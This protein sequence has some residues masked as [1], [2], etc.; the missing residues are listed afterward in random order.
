MRELPHQPDLS[1]LR[2][3]ARELQ[4]AAARGEV[5]TSEKVHAISLRVTLSSAQLALAREYGFSSWA[6]LKDEIERRAL[7]SP[8]HPAARYV[9][10]EVASLAELATAFDVIARQMSPSV[11]HDNRRFQDL[12]QRFPED[13]A[14]MLVVQ[15]QSRTVGGVLAVRKGWVGCNPADHRSRTERSQTGGSGDV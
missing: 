14:L 3:Q 5:A 10:R 1:Q 2:R 4:R 7:R 13:R 6:R 12:A 9:L 15:D 8:G 11:T